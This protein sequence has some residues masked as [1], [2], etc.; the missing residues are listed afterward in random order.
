[1]QVN[2]RLDDESFARLQAAARREGILVS[3]WL[4][5]QVQRGLGVEQDLVSRVSERVGLEVARRVEAALV[6][7]LDGF[8]DR[9]ARRVVDRVTGMS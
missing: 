9:V 4:R 2:F 7:V 6:D 3:E 8:E 1:M 5:R